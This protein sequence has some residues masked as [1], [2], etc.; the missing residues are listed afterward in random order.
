VFGISKAAG[1]YFVAK[2]GI[3]F[4]YKI[5]PLFYGLIC[6]YAI[7]LIFVTSIDQLYFVICFGSLSSSLTGPGTQGIPMDFIERQWYVLFQQKLKMVLAIIG[8]IGGL[9]GGLYIHHSHTPAPH[10]TQ[11]IGVFRYIFITMFVFN[12]ILFFYSFYFLKRYDNKK[13]D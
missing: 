2:V 4:R 10:I 13:S 11:E 7:A 5:L 9:L 1:S 8:A 3:R 6:I 12:L